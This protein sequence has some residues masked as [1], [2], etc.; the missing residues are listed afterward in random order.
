MTL[1]Q[2][3][4]DNRAELIKRTR[5]KV[6]GRSSP[7]SNP[8]ELEHGV[9]LFLTQLS[10]TLEEQGVG[11]TDHSARASHAAQPAISESAA[12]HGRELLKFGFSIDQVVHDYGDICQAVTEL[13]EERKINL[14]M[15]EFHTLNRCL[16][17]AIAG[18][19]SSWSEARDRKRAGKTDEPLGTLVP[20][21]RRLLE[22]AQT[23][24]DV[25][26]EGRV[27]PGGATGTLLQR[28]LVEMRAVLDRVEAK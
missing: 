10:A 11:G 28:A 1:D 12:Q 27:A 5:A 13:A 22:Q 18:A 8:A 4:K 16:D 6:A 23:S 19:V 7:P 24:F 9:P 3:L 2:F 17:N 15:A 20:D 25:I 21:V 26:R 14:S